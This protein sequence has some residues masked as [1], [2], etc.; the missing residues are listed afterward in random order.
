MNKSFRYVSNPVEVDAIK[1]SD[2][3]NESN[4][5]VAL[6]GWILPAIVNGAVSSDPTGVT[7][8]NTKQGKVQVHPTDWLIRLDDGEIYPCSDEV[9]KT[10]YS[11]VTTEDASA[12][13]GRFHGGK[14]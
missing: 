4:A 11:K 7:F 9:F 12:D 10:K 5:T 1:M 2:L 13:T 3:E 6:P 8:C 14:G